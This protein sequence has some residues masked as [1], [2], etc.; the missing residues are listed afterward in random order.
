M[1]RAAAAVALAAALVAWIPSC[2]DVI[3]LGAER[4]VADEL[5][6]LLE[7]CYGDLVPDDCR[8]RVGTR[9]EGAEQD[10]TTAWLTGFADA[11]CL[12][13]CT[14]ARRCLDAVPVCGGVGTECGVLEECCGFTLGKGTCDGDAGRCCRPRGTRCDEDADCCPD[15]GRCAA[16]TGTCGGV[17]CKEAGSTCAFDAEC[18]TK[19]C[20]D[21]GRCTDTVCQPDGALCFEDFECCTGLC[22]DG[23]CGIPGCGGETAPCFDPAEC[24][25]GLTC[26]TGA[27]GVGVCSINACLPDGL[28]CLDPVECC[29]GYCDP[30]FALCGSVP[31][32]VDEG[33]PCNPADIC[34]SGVCNESLL[35][36]CAGDGFLCTFPSDCCSG[37]CEGGACG[38]P[39][40]GS[41]GAECGS[42]QDCCGGSLCDESACVW[43]CGGQPGPFVCQ[44][45]VDL[46]AVSG[47]ALDPSCPA[48]AKDAEC[49][50]SI[51]ATDAFCCCN[52]WDQ[53]CVNEVGSICGLPC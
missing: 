47:S 4:N 40:C 31:T 7:R 6:E 19:I 36:G 53:Q 17:V 41:W 25:P 14:S 33:Q 2:A 24:C 21:S 44:N 48:S 16:E 20:D 46:C 22:A 27:E 13:D 39:G 49:V 11:G 52:Y 45:N 34:C 51:C 18:C 43:S 50:A 15:A 9:L 29:G 28:P 38:T 1:R 26:F 35:C 37:I 3:G 8:A 32:C 12:A 23:T 10:V 30:T 5:C 42:D